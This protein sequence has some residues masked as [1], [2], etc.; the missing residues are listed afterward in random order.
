MSDNIYNQEHSK[1]YD[2]PL[3][4]LDFK[5]IKECG[6][7]VE[8][9]K[10]MKT[11]K[12]GEVGVY[13][14]LESCCEERIRSIN[15]NSR[16]LRVA[17]PLGRLS[18]LDAE[19]R[20]EVKKGLQDWREEMEAVSGDIVPGGDNKED[21][22]R[23]YSSYIQTDETQKE[24]DTRTIDYDVDLPPVRK[25]MVFKS[26]SVSALRL[27]ADEK[28]F[29]S[30]RGTKPKDYSEWDKLE[31]EWDKELEDEE[32]QTAGQTQSKE[33]CDSNNTTDE[34]DTFKKMSMREF[35]ERVRNLSESERRQLA[36]RE[37]EK[38]NEAF[39]AKD[40]SEALAYYK[41]SL[42]IFPTNAVH[43]N[44]ALVYLHMKRWSDAVRECNQVLKEEPNNLKALFR[45][46]RANYELHNLDRAEEHLERLTD[47]DPANT[48]AQNLLRSV[49]AEKAKRQT[50]KHNGGRRLVIT[51]VG[52]SSESSDSESETPASGCLANSEDNTPRILVSPSSEKPSEEAV[53]KPI[54]DQTI[55]TSEKHT[56]ALSDP[57]A[58]VEPKNAVP[59]QSPDPGKNRQDTTMVEVVGSVEK[60][61]VNT[62][63]S[64]TP[65]QR[66]DGSSSTNEVHE[67]SNESLPA[68]GRFVEK[69]EPL[70]TAEKIKRE[71]I[72]EEVEERFVKDFEKFKE[73]GKQALEKGSYALALEHYSKCTELVE[74]HNL[75]SERSAMA[76]RNRAM[77]YLQ[78]GN[79]KLAVED[80]TRALSYEPE[81]P[82][83]LYRRALGLRYL[84]QYERS[85][86]DLREAHRLRPDS[87]NIANELKRVEKQ[88]AHRKGLTQTTELQTVARLSPDKR[89]DYEVVDPQ[90]TSTTDAKNPGSCSGDKTTD[91]E[92]EVVSLPSTADSSLQLHQTHGGTGTD[93]S[94]LEAEFT[95]D[96]IVHASPPCNL[97]AGI[98]QTRWTNLRTMSPVKR[99]KEI[100]CLLHDIGISRLTEVIGIKLDAT[101]LD[102]IVEAI[103]WISTEQGHTAVLQFAYDLLLQLSKIPR[104]DCALLLLEDRT[105]QAINNVLNK[106]SQL[107]E[108][109]VTHEEVE[110]LRRTYDSSI[111]E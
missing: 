44:R 35:S 63:S 58:G 75:G 39:Q 2:I 18:D 100:T 79:Y 82:A 16:V 76:Y 109:K 21:C 15:P 66:F 101:M 83:A 110:I 88:V 12:S 89:V 45:S 85:L 108:K 37:K 70:N 67:D 106:F 99:N 49:R 10:I 41:R 43:N 96:Y 77:V 11:L 107:P 87:R 62:H 98:F 47:Q 3:N 74:R 48:K 33:M 5:Y 20:N 30:R 40:Y 60:Q 23:I 94:K 97:T 93:E 104:F 111:N 34:S 81:S 19:E 61:Q 64:A 54:A 91:T 90:L 92:W 78:S 17:V 9:E 8:L 22:A 36:I 46:G 57:V 26:D 71:A 42:K 32:K 68:H 52:S 69:G 102:Q 65:L 29:G 59:S 7:I 51:D 4:H 31:K 95:R 72:S 13:K 86:T 55:L 53:D 73:C 56:A 80:C 24:S 105:I 28:P 25:E 50:V 38:G 1:T 6:D 27:H 84:E 103:H 14:E